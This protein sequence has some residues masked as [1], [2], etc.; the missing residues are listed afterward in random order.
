[1]A[2]LVAAVATLGGALGSGM[3]DDDAVKAAAYGIDN[4]RFR[5]IELTVGGEFAAASIRACVD[6]ALCDVDELGV[7][8]LGQ[9]SEHGQG[10]DV[11]DFVAFHE[12][13]FAWPIR[14]R[15]DSAELS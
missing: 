12:D 8:V 2:W 3:E 5:K 13:A 14:S 11:V 7:G 15:E 9:L 1:M 6:D 10:A 4:A